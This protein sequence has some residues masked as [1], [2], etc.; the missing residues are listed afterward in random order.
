MQLTE[1]QLRSEQQVF[2]DLA[3]LC[4]S[5]GYVHAIAYFCWRDGLVSMGDELT[6]SD[7][8]GQYS[9]SRLI[10]SEIS[11]LI[12]LLVREQIDYSLPTPDDMQ[13]YVDRTQTLLEELHQA[14]A[15]CSFAGKDW[16]ELAESQTSPFANAAAMREPIFYGPESAYMFQYRDLA[17]RR[18]ADDDEWLKANYGFRSS[19]AHDVLR[20]ISDLQNR[21]FTD[22]LELLKQQHPDTWTVLPA[23]KFRTYEIAAE[24]GKVSDLVEKVIRAFTLPTDNRND[25]FTSLSAFNATNARPLIES[26]EGEFFLFQYYA[27][28]ESFYESPFYWMAADKAYANQALKNRGDFTERFA[29]E[30]LAAVFGEKNVFANVNL[31]DSSDR[32]VC[33]IDVLAVFADRA[34]VVQAKS[35]RLTISARSGNDRQLKDDFKKAVQDAYDQSLRCAKALRD[36][37]LKLRDAEGTVIE[38]AKRP[39]EIFPYCLVADH[40]PALAFQAREFLQYETTEAIQPPLV[41]DLFALDVMTEFL[42]SP[43]RLLSYLSL[44]ARFGDQV[45]ISH[46]LTAL[47][48]HLK[49]NLWVSDDLNMLMID[50]D[51]AIDLDIAMMARRDGIPGEKTPQGVLTHWQGTPIGNIVSQIEAEEHIAAVDLGFMLLALSQNTLDSLNKIIKNIT[52]RA[53]LDGKTHDAS[54]GFDASSSGLTIYSSSHPDAEVNRRLKAHCSFRKYATRARSWFGVLLDPKTKLIRLAVKLVGEW[55]QDDQMDKLVATL[56]K[57]TKTLKEAFNSRR[58]RKVGRNA[59]CPCGSGL[60]YKKCCL[61]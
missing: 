31:H 5:P 29:H 10:R 52:D 44:R 47:G 42:M 18:F 1:E 57:G 2:D 28:V 61:P 32:I 43:L 13:R 38:F 53:R 23:F 37:S 19:E 45:F 4:T 56:P 12:G 40:Y 24:S 35:K 51:I 9:L 59:P 54:L 49:K 60:K 20:A 36:S 3:D 21:K 33:E 14:L 39:I 25:T 58:T 26:E 22:L 50:N 27:L 7:L 17:P 48:F 30:R 8:E 15:R 41:T 11:T 34:I 16:G 6:P 55:V 46:E